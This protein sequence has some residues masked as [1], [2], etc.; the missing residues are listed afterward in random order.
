[1]SEY[2]HVNLQVNYLKDYLYPLAIIAI[3][4]VVGLVSGSY[5]SINTSRLNPLVMLKSRSAAASS[6]S[7]FRRLII[8]LQMV[9]FIGLISS[10]FIIFDQLHYLRNSDLG[11]D[12]EQLL[13]MEFTSGDFSAHYESFLA[14]LVANPNILNVAG[15]FYLPPHDGSSVGNIPHFDDPEQLVE[16]EYC[17]VD[18][19]FFETY[20]IDLLAGRFFSRDFADDTGNVVIVNKAAIEKLHIENPLEQTLEE[21]QIIGVVDDF[22]YHSL[23][24]ELKPMLFRLSPLAHI[25]EVGIR[26]SPHNIPESLK[27][28]EKTWN[29][30]NLGKEAPFA[31]SFVDDMF[32]MFYRDSMNFSKMIMYCTILAIFI[33]CLGLFGLTMFI[34]KQKSKEIGIR[35]VFGASSF[36][37]LKHLSLEIVWLSI[38]STLIA[39]PLVIYLM[40]KWLMNFAYHTD[41]SFWIFIIA[42]FTGLCISLLTMSFFSIK[43]SLANPVETMKYE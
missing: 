34:T 36:R 8:C 32:E 13:K 4:V 33:A 35:K 1:M 24:L 10:S 15:G 23:N 18:Y 30:F 2:L 5:I 38:V 17:S 31:F 42:G 12:K 20:N 27:F 43:A 40:N 39:V 3:T 22:H 11:Y 25:T 7:H 41:I 26:L 21:A 28:I 29:K 37:I 9:I 14:E 19:N 6:K 16:I